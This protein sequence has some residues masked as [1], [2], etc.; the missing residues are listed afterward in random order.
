V[1]L[2]SF[3]RHLSTCTL[4]YAQV[5]CHTVN[6]RIAPSSPTCLRTLE[7]LQLTRFI[8]AP[9][10]MM[11]GFL[12]DST[13]REGSDLLLLY[14]SGYSGPFNLGMELPNMMT[15]VPGFDEALVYLMVST[16]LLHKSQPCAFCSL[17]IDSFVL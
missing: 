15:I 13:L 11:Q 14:C 2:N 12:S 16:T 4:T 8:T 7:H 5:R 9:L 10:P 1:C 3:N 6:R 17:D